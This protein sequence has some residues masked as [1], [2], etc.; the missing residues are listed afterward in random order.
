MS[1][2]Y[3]L[4]PAGLELPDP[5]SFGLDCGELCDQP[6]FEVVLNEFSHTRRSYNIHRLVLKHLES[7]RCFDTYYSTHKN[8]G[9][10]WGAG[11]GRDA[12]KW[13][14]VFARESITVVYGPKP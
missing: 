14:E 11:A 8:E 5:E 10:E 4:T 9:F 1:N 6:D 2:L 7:G 12:P 13:R 3:K